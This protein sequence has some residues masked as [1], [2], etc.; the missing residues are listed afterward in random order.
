MPTRPVPRPSLR[1]ISGGGRRRRVA[2]ALALVIALAVVIGIM[3]STG[4]PSP[5]NAASNADNVAGATTVERRDLVETDT[6][7]G[8]LSYANP[9][10][11]YNRLS[12][13]ITWLPSVGQVIRPGQPLYKVDGEPVTLMDGSTPAYRDLTPS[14]SNGQ[15]IE[16]LN[17][18]LVDLDFNPDGITVND[19]WQAGTTA[20]IELFQESLGETPTGS[21][22]LGQIVF[23]PGP[24]L[25]AT[26]DATLG[27]TGSGGGGSGSGANPSSSADY[28]APVGSATPEFV[29]L[30]TAATPTTTTPTTTTPTST[31]KSPVTKP[32]KAEPKPGRQSGNA[33]STKTLAALIALLK[34][35]IAQLKAER[36]ASPTGGGTGSGTDAGSTGRS[37]AGSSGGGSSGA[38]H[39]AAGRP[40]AGRP[41]AG[42]LGEAPAAAGR[43]PRSCRRPRPSWS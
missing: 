12:G 43:P 28:T 14:D 27:S 8:T 11:V 41:A 25:I 20:G 5:T 18:N 13:T 10:T 30:K 29:S 42:H 22:S 35:E 4:S 37:G 7:S 33:E 31:P 36:S 32:E 39:R 1:L 38:A 34:A 2:A 19:T 15:D 9:Q 24:Q 6:E 40:A 16:Q 17:R 3:I 26:V 21:L 23:L